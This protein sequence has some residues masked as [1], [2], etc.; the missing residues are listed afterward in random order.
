MARKPLRK[1]AQAMSLVSRHA[2][3]PLVLARA[4][5]L[6]NRHQTGPIGHIRTDRCVVSITFD[7]F[8]KSA[9]IQGARILERAGALGT[10]Y[11]CAEFA[12]TRT[13][14]GE[15]FDAHDIRTLERAGHEIGCH[16]F[17]HLN[18]CLS[19]ASNISAN[20]A[21]NA[22][23][24]E[25]LGLEQPMN[26]FAFPY[27]DA[28]PWSRLRLARR[29]LTLRGIR[30][31]VNRGKTDLSLLSAQGL[32][33]SEAD[34]RRVRSKFDDLQ[35]GGG[36]LIL[37]THEVDDTPTPFGIT[38]QGLEAIVSEAKARGFWLRKMRDAAELMI[39][40]AMPPEAA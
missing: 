26:S 13:L 29:F 21:R 2:P 1:G 35:E 4:A 36:W 20:V 38:P 9:A 12:G 17:D 31:G 19:S 33:P 24:M 30:S 32:G 28:S 23:A 8:P 37:F 16:T 27:G 22:R 14:H 39:D 11:A 10:Y 18:C 15:S 34:L 5:R 6:I 3:L 40:P 25:V 7:D